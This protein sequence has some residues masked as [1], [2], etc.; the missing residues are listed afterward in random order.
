[1]I[2]SA[3]RAVFWPTVFAIPALLVL[4][5]LGTWQV[6]RLQWKE[7]LIETIEA[8][9]TL[10]AIP[11]AEA[12][13]LNVATGDIE[14]VHTRASGRFDHAAER[15]FYQTGPHGPGW[16]IYTPLRLARGRILWVNR[17]YV[18]LAQK[19]AQLRPESQPAGELPT[20]E[21][22]VSGLLRGPSRQRLFVPD[23]NQENNEWYWLDLDAMSKGLPGDP[24]V[25]PFVLEADANTS[26][27][28]LPIGGVTIIDLP[29]SHFGYALTWYGLA[30]T[31]LLVYVPFIAGRLK[32]QD[33]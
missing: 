25:L 7:S 33:E 31:L 6:Q 11:L 18:P 8:R 14:Y 21:V 27:E 17:G 28:T 3:R 22:T 19:A 9:T 29:N 15:H 20:D 24:Q 1:M 13:A 4:L 12:E 30:I 23:N 32:K 2:S 5:G 10:P 16:H 26:P